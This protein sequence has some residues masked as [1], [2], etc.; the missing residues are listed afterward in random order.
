MLA[1]VLKICGSCISV[2]TGTMHL[3]NALQV[4][5]VEIFYAWGKDFWASDTNLYPAKVLDNGTPNDIINAYQE[6]MGACV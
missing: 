1:N 5:V 4:P 3:A 6:L 2:D